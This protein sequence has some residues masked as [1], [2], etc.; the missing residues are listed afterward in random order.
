MATEIMKK[1]LFP[2]CIGFMD[3][4]LLPLEF[5]PKLHGEAYYSRK[6]FYA[7][8]MLVICDQNAQIIY[9][10]VGWLGC[11]RSSIVAQF[12]NV[13]GY[14]A[15]NEYL[16]ADS[17]FSPSVHVITASKASAGCQIDANQSNFND[18]L[19]TPRVK[20]EHCGLTQRSF[21]LAKEYP[22]QNKKSEEF[23]TDY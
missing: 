22:Y 5:K 1:W 15:Q 17:A 2:N 11:P 12:Q 6:G 13:S 8:N 14:F 4:T 19:A 23:A 16:L 9:Y 7:I 20:S 10:M 18:M 21:S 3:D